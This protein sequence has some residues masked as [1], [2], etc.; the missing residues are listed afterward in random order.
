MAQHNRDNAH[1]SRRDLIA[2]ALAGALALGARAP[3]AQAIGRPTRLTLG[4]VEIPGGEP[5]PRPGVPQA[6]LF[7]LARNTSVD[8]RADCPT[9]PFTDKAIYDH[10]LLILAGGQAFPPLP[11]AHREGLGNYLKAGG[12]LF[13][14]DTSGLNRSPFADSLARELGAIFPGRSLEKLERSHAIYRSFFLMNRVA[15]RV[16]LRPYVEGLT[17]GDISPVILSRNDML[18]ALATDTSGS[19]VFEAVPGGEGQRALAYKLGINVIMYALTLN[20]KLDATH[21][22]ALLGKRRGVYDE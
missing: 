13:A 17:I 5:F 7:E 11:P 16:A 2:T 3:V 12:M 18:G 10:P 6:L 8:V 22:R 21:V 19:Y 9:L 20:Y 4:L 1:I 15:G 14:D